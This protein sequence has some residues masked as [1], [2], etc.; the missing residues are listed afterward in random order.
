VRTPGFEFC[1]STSKKVT[2]LIPLNILLEGEIQDLG[3]IKRR[4]KPNLKLKAPS[5]QVA[6]FPPLATS[7]RYGGGLH[8]GLDELNLLPM[9]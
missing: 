6:P 7:L 2:Q 9:P 4:R 3:I 1:Q 8:G 5:P